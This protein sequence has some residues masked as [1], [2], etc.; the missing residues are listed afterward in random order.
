MACLYYIFENKLS[1][2]KNICIN[3]AYQYLYNVDNNI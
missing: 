3:N 2:K 1:S